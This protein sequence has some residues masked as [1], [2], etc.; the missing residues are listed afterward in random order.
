LPPSRDYDH[1]ITLKPDA[2]PFNAR[3]NRYSPKHKTEIENQVS[4]MLEA[5][6]IKQSMSPFASPVLLIL[7]KDGS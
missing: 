5:C 7:K 1:A 3:P 4:M 6:I 2:A